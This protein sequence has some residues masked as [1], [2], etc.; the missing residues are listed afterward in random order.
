MVALNDCI[1]Y[2]EVIDVHIFEVYDLGF[3]TFIGG[4][5]SELFWEFGGS[6]SLWAIKN[7]KGP[8]VDLF[9]VSMLL[10]G[11][12]DGWVGDDYFASQEISSHE[13]DCQSYEDVCQH[14]SDELN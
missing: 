7:A 2:I 5:F 9:N 4:F 6:A 12:E 1:D 8:I 3:K 13:D 11:V 10:L 14:K